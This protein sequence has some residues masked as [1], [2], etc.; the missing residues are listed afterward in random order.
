MSR[1]DLCPSCGHSVRRNTTPVCAN[2]AHD[3]GTT[4]SALKR[5]VERRITIRKSGGDDRYSWALFVDGRRTFAGMDRR[6]AMWRRNN[7]VSNLMS[8]KAWNA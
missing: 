6:E 3:L 7:A 1:P 4:Y 2:C 8:G 5:N